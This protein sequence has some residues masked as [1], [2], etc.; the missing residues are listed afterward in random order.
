MQLEPDQ[1][2]NMV[3]FPRS[4]QWSRC[5]VARRA[6]RDS[7]LHQR[8]ACHFGGSRECRR[9]V[10]CLGVTCKALGPGVR[11][12]DESG[13]ITLPGFS[14][15]SY[16]KTQ[17]FFVRFRRFVDWDDGVKHP[18]SRRTGTQCLGRGAGWNDGVKP[19]APEALDPVSSAIHGLHGMKSSW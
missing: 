5:C 3:A 19:R 6:G 16:G 11:R 15:F 12:D 17:H 1:C 14:V 18:S 9:R 4:R 2:M 7:R 8:K 13:G 10:V